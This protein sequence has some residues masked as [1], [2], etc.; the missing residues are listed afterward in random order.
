MRGFIHR[1]LL[2]LLVFAG[3]LFM[4]LSHR[5]N[6]GMYPYLPVFITLLAVVVSFVRPA[7]K[8]EKKVVFHEIA[9]E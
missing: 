6:D 5:G 4:V 2:G 3:L 8:V 1:T 7:K 9:G